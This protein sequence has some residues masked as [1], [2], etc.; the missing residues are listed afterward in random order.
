MG[1]RNRGPTGTGI[2]ARTEARAEAGVE[3]GIEARKKLTGRNFA[4]RKGDGETPE[5][6]PEAQARSSAQNGRK[7]R[8][9]WSEADDTNAG[10]PG[11][12]RQ[13][14]DGRRRLPFLET[15]P[16]SPGR[17]AEVRRKLARRRTGTIICLRGAETGVER[18]PEAGSH[19]SGSRSGSRNGSRSGSRNGSGPEGRRKG[20]GRQPEDRWK[21]AGR[22][23]EGGWKAQEERQNHDRRPRKHAGG[24]RE[25]ARSFRGPDHG[26]APVIDILTRLNI[27]QHT[28]L[29]IFI[30]IINMK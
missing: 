9:K 29:L 26:S 7:R 5:G 11:R 10:T 6:P 13:K 15:R 16:N 22:R 28:W 1:A 27:I 12:G 24:G 21:A 2:E 3:A 30:D 25:R 14:K 23:L 20:A 19:A 8:W 17:Y 18:R 4:P